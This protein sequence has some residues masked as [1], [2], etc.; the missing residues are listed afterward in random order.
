MVQKPCR[1]YSAPAAPLHGSRKG[2]RTCR[3]L[4]GR[5]SIVRGDP[6]FQKSQREEGKV[7]DKSGGWG[8]LLM[9]LRAQG[10]QGG[11]SR[12]RGRILKA[13]LKESN[14]DKTKE[15]GDALG[16]QAS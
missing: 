12:G 7:T 15:Q 4:R 3:H 16:V 14:E 9:T 2:K 11:D 8:A 5:S 13:E 6:G 1:G 10:A